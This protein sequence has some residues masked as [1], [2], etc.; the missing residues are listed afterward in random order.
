MT[1][2]KFNILIIN[3]SCRTEGSHSRDM[4]ETVKNALIKSK[5]HSKVIYRDIGAEQ[6]SGPSGEWV[7]ANC[8]SVEHRT[9]E[10]KKILEL[11]DTMISELFAADV[12]VFGCPMYNLTITST[13]KSY[14]DQICRAGIT[15]KYGEKGVEG[16]LE[17]KK[18][19]VCTTSGGVP[20]GAPSDFCTPYME[21]ICKMIGIDDVTFFSANQNMQNTESVME[22]A[23]AK[24]MN[25]LRE[26]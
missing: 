7:A 5:P 4:T 22:K 19:I 11:S 15:F 24:I 18:A 23:N 21:A 3:S 1:P 25:E 26:E 6:L 2:T 14:F 20:A 9:W 10:Q 8:T 13:L 12:V 17:N 16:L